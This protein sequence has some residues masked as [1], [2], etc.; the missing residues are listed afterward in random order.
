MLLLLV[1]VDWQNSYRMN[2]QVCMKLNVVDPLFTYKMVDSTKFDTNLKFGVVGNFIGKKRLV[3]TKINK[4]RMYNTKFC[5]NLT[6]LA[7]Y[8][9]RFIMFFSLG[10]YMELM[11]IWI[12]I[13]PEILTPIAFISLLPI[14]LIY[15]MK[16]PCFV[17]F[18]NKASLQYM[19]GWNYFWNYTWYGKKATFKCETF[20]DWLWEHFSICIP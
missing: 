9:L 20:W 16:K 2:G 3:S 8:V 10:K 1:T 17:F 13:L 5:T 19:F 18:S 14:M 12:K 6:V 11:V 15:F 7:V 4:K